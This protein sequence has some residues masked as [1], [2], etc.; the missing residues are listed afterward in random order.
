[1]SDVVAVALI[2]SL[3][4]AG[5]AIIGSVLGL[6]RERFRSNGETQRLS[7]QLRSEE[8]RARAEAVRDTRMAAAD[9]LRG[10]IKRNVA[11]GLDIKFLQAHPQSPDLLKLMDALLQSMRAPAGEASVNE[12]LS[13]FSDIA[14]IDKVREIGRTMMEI[15]QLLVPVRGLVGKGPLD[16]QGIQEFRNL[17]APVDQKLRQLDRDVAGLNSLLEGYTIGSDLAG[18]I[19]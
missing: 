6:L 3:S 16:A 1:M 18:S 15:D 5:V 2:T 4:T 9:R 17:Y 12:V 7:S 11:T 8:A 10:W 14:I 19:A 13:Y